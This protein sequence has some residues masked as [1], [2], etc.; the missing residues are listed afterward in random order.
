MTDSLLKNSLLVQDARTKRRNA[1]EKRFKAYGIAVISI[2]FFM[3]AVLLV[4]LFRR[5]IG[6]FQQTFVTLPVELLEG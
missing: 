6:A 3:L 2:G 4:T 1:A 5:G